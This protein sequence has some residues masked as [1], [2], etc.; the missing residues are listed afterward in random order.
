MSERIDWTSLR[1]QAATNLSEAA[2]PQKG[3]GV[4]QA[5]TFPRNGR[6]GTTPRRAT[7]PPQRCESSLP[8]YSRTI[9]TLS[10]IT[11]FSTTPRTR[12]P[13]RERNAS[14]CS[15]VLRGEV[16][17]RGADAVWRDARRGVDALDARDRPARPTLLPP[18]ALTRPFCL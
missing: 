3:K 9:S 10:G 4:E 5:R 15:V 1:Q 17:R 11:L 12:A 13:A 8:K 18:L 16:V 2:P 6:S 14:A 7:L